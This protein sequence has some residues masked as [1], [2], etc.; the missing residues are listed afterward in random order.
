MNEYESEANMMA[1]YSFDEPDDAPKNMRDLFGPGHVDQA[2]RQAIMHCWMMMPPDKKNPA[3]VAAQIRRI[4]ERALAN[5]EEDAQAFGAGG[6][7][8]TRL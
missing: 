1:V 5:L 6:A 7:A 8:T 3:A 4:V 2:I